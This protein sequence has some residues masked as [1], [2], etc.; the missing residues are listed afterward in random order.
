L[1][2]RVVIA[3]VALATPDIAADRIA[4]E[5]AGVVADVRSEAD[6]EAAVDQC[7]ATFGALDTLILAAGVLSGGS[8]ATSSEADW[9]LTIDVNL[10][11]AYMAAR[12]ATSALSASGRGRIVGISSDA[13]RRGFAGSA[14]Y[15]A[16]KFGLIGLIESIAAELSEV[17]VTANVV[18]PIGVPTTEMGQ[19][20]LERQMAALD[21]TREEILAAR[22][23]G[24]PLGRNATE[25]D[26]AG[27][28][29]F[30]VSDEAGFLTGVSIDVD[31]GTHL[32]RGVL[33][34][35]R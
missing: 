1:G 26:V 24:V 22:A 34:P 28:V 23:R 10:K 29:A 20:I 33:I 30:F 5:A 4:G 17:G 35:W 31:G 25:G 6:M 3:D 14:A 27:A 7:I 19:A 16:S 11:G 9:D 12:A 8:L 13:G 18:C 15:C 21:Q 2:V 32:G